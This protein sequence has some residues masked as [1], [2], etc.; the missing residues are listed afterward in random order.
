MKE[1]SKKLIPENKLKF[2]NFLFERR[3]AYL[4]RD[5]TENI[6]LNNEEIFFDLEQF[7]NCHSMS[8]DDISKMSSIIIKEIEHIGWKTKL[9]YGNTAMFIYSTEQPPPNCYEEF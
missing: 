9:T 1:F 3:L 7:R 8:T 6:L 4:R 5:I 2:S